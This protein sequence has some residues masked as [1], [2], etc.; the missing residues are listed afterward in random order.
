[1]LTQLGYT[2]VSRT[3][4]MKALEEF[5][6]APEDYSLV[7]TDQT[8]PNMTGVELSRALLQ[9]REDLPIILCTGFSELIDEEKA[10]QEGIKEFILK[11]IIMKDMART[12]RTL[13]DE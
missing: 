9:V 5:K 6:A 12:V 8:M 3:S 4:S 1:M 2:V 10:K 11:P 13:L 7:I